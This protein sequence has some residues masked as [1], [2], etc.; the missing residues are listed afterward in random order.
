MPELEKMQSIEDKKDKKSYKALERVTIDDDLKDKLNSLKDA[1]NLSLQGI[2]EVSK[3]DVVN[4]ILKLHPDHLSKLETD[5]LRKTHFDVFKCLTW[6]Q[7]QAKVAK[8]SGSE[9]SL[10]DLIAKSSELMANE[11]GL[12]LQKIRKPRKRKDVDLASEATICGEAAE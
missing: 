10:K 9:V 8:D 5:E 2:T 1:A 11:V 4:M 7:N 3:S 6:L 12:R